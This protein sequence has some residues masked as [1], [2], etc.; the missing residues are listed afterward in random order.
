MGRQSK[1][2]D[3]TKLAVNAVPTTKYRR[4]CDIDRYRAEQDKWLDYSLPELVVRPYTEFYRLAWRRQIADNTERSL[5]ATLVP[6]GPA[7]V[8]LVHSLAFPSAS[9]TVLASGFWAAIPV[10]YALRVTGRADLGKADTRMM[11][12]PETDHLLAAPLLLRTLRLNCLTEAYADL[13]SELYDPMWQT[14]AWACNWP[15]LSAL[16]NVGCDWEWGTPLRTEYARRAAL[17]E[18]DALVAVWLGLEIDEFLAA[19]ESR[20]SVL[21]DHEAEM[22]FDANGRK[23]AADYDSW[24]HGQTKEHWKQFE[25]YRG[26]DPATDPPPAGYT[27]PFYKADRISEYQQAY[28]VFSERLRKARG[29]DG[30]R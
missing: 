29:E 21:A 11:P 30:T 20:F 24:G 15:E 5:I 25:M 2:C 9:E 4:N 8:H 7:H 13:W 12:T 22:Y 3:L 18:I 28:A 1:I 19:Y 23:L 14:E 10:D 27:A 16:E 6:P 17:V 26:D